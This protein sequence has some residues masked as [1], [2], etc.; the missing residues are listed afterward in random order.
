MAATQVTQTVGHTAQLATRNATDTFSR[1][2]EGDDATHARAE[3]RGTA[4]PAKRD[5]W[6]SFGAAPSGPSKD[7][8]DFWDSFGA[9]PASEDGRA[10]KPVSVGT[11]AMRKGPSGSSLLNNKTPRK[12]GQEDEWGEW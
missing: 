6:D 9:A 11:A 1:F 7:K 2:V 10:S 4:E 5:F 3:A 12:D 8:Q